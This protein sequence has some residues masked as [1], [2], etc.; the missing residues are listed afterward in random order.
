MLVGFPQRPEMAGNGG[1]GRGM[2]RLP[3]MEA[4]RAVSSPQ[5]KGAGAFLDVTLEV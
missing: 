1:R 3:S 4:I 5:D 2:P